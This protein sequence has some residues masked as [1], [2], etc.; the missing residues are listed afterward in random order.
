M[1]FDILKT[2]RRNSLAHGHLTDGLSNWD[3]L[4]ILEYRK[5]SGKT[6]SGWEFQ[7]IPAIKNAS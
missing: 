1:T 5:L 6:F 4:R 7:R 3:I 2:G